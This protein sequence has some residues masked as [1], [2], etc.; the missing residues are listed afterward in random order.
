MGWMY[1]EEKQRKLVEEDNGMVVQE[2]LKGKEEEWEAEMK[3][4]CGGST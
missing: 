4:T 2:K 1:C 3:V